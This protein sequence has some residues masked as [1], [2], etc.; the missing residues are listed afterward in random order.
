[1]SLSIA[2]RPLAEAIANFV[3]TQLHSNG[4]FHTV[5]FEIALVAFFFLLGY[6]EDLNYRQNSLPMEAAVYP[7]R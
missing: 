7:H 3:S 4:H 2:I 6:F 5:L 1:M